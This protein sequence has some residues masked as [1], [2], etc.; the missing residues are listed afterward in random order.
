MF[1]DWMMVLVEVE[2]L[3]VGDALLELI[4]L[5]QLHERINK[6]RDYNQMDKERRGI[7]VDW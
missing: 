7:T 4:D 1:D 6:M 3:A 5:L 2:D